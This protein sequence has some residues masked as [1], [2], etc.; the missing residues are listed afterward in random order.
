MKL[1]LTPMPATIQEANLLDF[2][3]T[4]KI[5]VWLSKH[6]RIAC[7]RPDAI[8]ECYEI[9][10]IAVNLILALGINAKAS[11]LYQCVSVIVI[12]AACY[13]Q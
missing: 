3:S 9:C 12:T 7:I 8:M 11:H 10:L 13:C 4:V 5:L 1:G 2:D 6:V